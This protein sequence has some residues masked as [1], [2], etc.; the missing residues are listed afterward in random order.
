MSVLKLKTTP[1]CSEKKYRFCISDSTKSKGTGNQFRQIGKQSRNMSG[2]EQNKTKK[3]HVFICIRE[4]CH[5][6]KTKQKIIFINI[7]LNVHLLFSI[8]PVLVV[9][10]T[11]AN[12]SMNLFS[13]A[14]EENPSK[15]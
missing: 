7:T 1:A 6:K 9:S 2:E 15:I 13:S 10:F 14:S 8:I 5:S 11:S 4:P 3:R 12:F